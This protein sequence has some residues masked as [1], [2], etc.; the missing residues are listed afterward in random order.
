MNF[1]SFLENFDQIKALSEVSVTEFIL[2]SKE[3]SR[4][5]RLDEFQVKELALEVSKRGLKAILEW[6][7]LMT[8]EAFELACQNLSKYNLEEFYAVRVQD[9]GALFFLMEKYP[10][11]KI[12]LNLE[13]G[14][15][16]YR[17]IK[18]WVDLVGD[19]LDKIIL[20]P[21]LNHEKIKSYINSFKNYKF[22]FE[23]LGLGRVLLFYTPRNLLSN[24]VQ[25]K[26]DLLTAVGKSEETPHKGFNILEN[27]HGTF[28]FNPKDLCLLDFKDEIASFGELNLRVDFRHFSSPQTISDFG[29]LSFDDFKNKY[30]P[31]YTKGFFRVNKTKSVFSR[32]KNSK[33]IRKDED[34]IGQ[35][36]AV[37]KNNY[38]AIQIKA[39]NQEV[40]VGD[41]LGYHTPDGKIKKHKIG[42]L[43]NSEN[44]GV[45]TGLDNQLVMVDHI[46]GVS[47]KTNVY[48]ESS[49][50]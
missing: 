35:I 4:Y 46:T 32:L 45:E 1:T 5:G 28:M 2:S 25:R 38:L 15:H 37:K 19:Q 14:N 33:L 6:D 41:I 13:T 44:L 49:L 36:M 40:K 27:R 22:S 21:E 17:G 30:L 18:G 31:K 9:P 23:L 20:S 50:S 24:Q 29:G 11:V 34:Y 47:I 10:S 12:Q 39:K 8:S 7:I 3:L 48:R 26:G 43:R 16:N 42:F